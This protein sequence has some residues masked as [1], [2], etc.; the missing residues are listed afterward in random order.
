[1]RAARLVLA[2]VLAIVDAKL[3]RELT[4]D[5]WGQVVPGHRW[6]V[7][8]TLSGCK[9]C[10]RLVPMMERLAELA[11]DV[12]VGRIDASTHNGLARTYAVKRFP[13]I[14]LLDQD[15]LF[16]E[17]EG[18]RSLQS[19]LNFGRAAPGAL[20]GGMVQPEEILQMRISSN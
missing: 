20:G 14:L 11:P 3:V 13:T 4:P 15:G 9:H 5:R 8:F 7:F 1:M 12:M 10:E 2:V 19:L 17:F 6:L 16:Y 18:P